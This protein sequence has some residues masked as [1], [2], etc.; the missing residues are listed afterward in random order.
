MLGCS[1]NQVALARP[2]IR[3]NDDDCRLYAA[4]VPE[5]NELLC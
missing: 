5:T 3:V 4:P 2:V 1:T